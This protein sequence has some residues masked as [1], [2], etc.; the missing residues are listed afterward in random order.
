[1]IQ[2][3]QTIHLLLSV[4][5]GIVVA[6][7][8]LNADYYFCNTETG[9]SYGEIIRYSSIVLLIISVVLAGRSIFMYKRRP[10]Q[11]RMVGFATFVLVLNYALLAAGYML[12]LI[13]TPWLYIISY[14]PLGCIIFNTLARKRIRFDENLVRS[15]DR[16]R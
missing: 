8:M 6:I 1:M 2:R 5:M 12:D 14:L 7:M 11:M 9:Q 3:I 15:A 10:A 16:L 13:C 4:I